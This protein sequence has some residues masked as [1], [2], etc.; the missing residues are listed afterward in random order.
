MRHTVTAERPACHIKGP[1]GGQRGT[2][3]RKKRVRAERG[4]GGPRGQ[5]AHRQVGDAAPTSLRPLEMQAHPQ[6]AETGY[7][8]GPGGGQ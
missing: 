7:H 6:T 3:S 2:Q 1:V 5:G 4:P 8:C